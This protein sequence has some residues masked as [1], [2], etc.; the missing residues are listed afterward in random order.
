[1]PTF[2]CLSIPGTDHVEL[3][4]VVLRVDVL[5]GLAEADE[6]RDDDAIAGGDQWPML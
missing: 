2:W 4:V 1:M 3:V 5:V 6:I